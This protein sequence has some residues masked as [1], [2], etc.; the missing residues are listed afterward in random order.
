[1]SK[2]TLQ[3]IHDDE[4]QQLLVGLGLDEKIKNGKVKCKFCKSIITTDNIH[5]IFPEA[6]SVK[7]VCDSVNCIKLLTDFLNSGKLE[8]RDG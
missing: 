2:K 7:V 8:T 1:M 5:S 6:G 3:L 4:L